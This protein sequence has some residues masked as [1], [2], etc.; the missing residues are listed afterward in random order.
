M[1]IISFSKFVRNKN[2]RQDNV[3]FYDLDS[4]FSD[5]TIQFSCK[6]ENHPDIPK[7]NS[8]SSGADDL[9]GGKSIIM[10]SRMNAS[11]VSIWHLL[12]S[13]LEPSY[14]ESQH[15]NFINRDV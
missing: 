5:S 14:K 6:P 4:N 13:D 10:H 1:H 12:A 11:P 9:S 7:R 8:F 15:R 2:I 3:K